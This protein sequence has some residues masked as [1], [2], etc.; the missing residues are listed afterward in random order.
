MVFLHFLNLLEHKSNARWLRGQLLVA[1]MAV[2]SGS[3]RSLLAKD[4]ELEREIKRYIL[5]AASSLGF[6]LRTEQEEV[7]FKALFPFPLFL[8]NLYFTFTAQSD[9]LHPVDN[10]SNGRSTQT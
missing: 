9:L 1:V 10:K 8:A 2:G 4:L 6:N 7:F 5:D 3:C